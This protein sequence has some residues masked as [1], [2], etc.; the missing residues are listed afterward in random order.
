[1]VNDQRKVQDARDKMR[2]AEQAAIVVVLLIAAALRF[3]ALADLPLG[4]DQ[5]EI[6][7][8]IAIRGII[9]G[10]RPIFITAGWG[11]EPVYAY[12]A[13]AIVSLTSDMALG[14]RLTTVMFSM[15]FLA[16]AYV[17][18]RRLFG[19][20]VALMTLGWLAL[21]FWPLMTSRAGERNILLALFTALT[22]YLFY[23]ALRSN[24]NP[25]KERG[26]GFQVS[27]FKR[28]GSNLKF[29]I[30]YLRFDIWCLKFGLAGLAL[31]AMLWT[32]Q[33]SRI[34][35][36]VF[37][38]FATY[39]AVWEPATFRVNWKGIAVFLVVGVLIASPLL[40]YL[41][42]HPGA[43]VGDFK[44]Q[45]LQ[46][47]RQ[48]DWEPMVSAAFGALGLFTVRGEIYWLHNIPGRPIFDWFSGVL[49]YVGLGMAV[50]QGLVRR[51]REC[52]LLLLWLAIG[53][54]PTMITDP[55]S[56]HRM[57]NVMAAAYMLPAIG[58]DWIRHKLD[59]LRFTFYVSR[60]ALYATLIAFLLAWTGIT[61]AHDFFGVWAIA[62]Q[63]QDLR[64]AKLAQL[65]RDLDR[66]PDTSPVVVAGTYI[67]DIEPLVPVALMHRHDISFRWYAADSAQVVPGQVSQARYF[68]PASGL[69]SVD[70]DT[71]R[72]DLLTRASVAP[73]AW[74]APPGDAL[75]TFV[76]APAV[77]PISFDG[78]VEFLGAEILPPHL[79]T[80]WRVLRDGSPSSTAMFVH[81]TTPD[82]KIIAQD[83]RLGF[84]THSWRADDVFSQTFTLNIPASSISQTWIEIGIYDRPTKKRWEVTG[85]P[86]VNRVLAQWPV[87]NGQ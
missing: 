73:D 8:A 70:T 31:G 75:P 50:W 5:D 86:G 24:F 44:T 3:Y 11:R 62:P 63:V 18:A 52:I 26:A 20:A 84:P 68:D 37:L 60:F 64:F 49:F 87:I 9:A 58:V 77:R 34:M 1:V 55:P 82:L 48:G 81:L 66:D 2:R 13:A 12:A 30:W 79:V 56:H 23:R 54:I 22:V 32:Y 47:L 17:T 27:N 72:R 16:V 71:L 36:V 21:G 42:T 45:S 7:N 4:L 25:S 59:A 85:A 78:R 15:V 76:G 14:M 19:R 28:R 10:E 69:R 41:V 40:I 29:D 61:T 53:L 83:D 33:S 39:L 67:E 57:A 65:S 51:R 43:E 35:P 74:L 80:Y 38:A 6:I 46:A